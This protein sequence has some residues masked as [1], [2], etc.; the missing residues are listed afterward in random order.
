[1]KKIIAIALM[2]VLTL[3]SLTG[4]SGSKSETAATDSQATTDVAATETPE[5]KQLVI[6]VSMNSADEYAT[7]WIELF[8]KQVEEKGA[9]V[10]ST[11][12][13]SK[14]DKQLADIDT[15][16]SQ[17]PDVILV[18]PSDEMGIVSGLEAVNNANIPLIVVDGSMQ[19]N[20][21]GYNP[22][23]DQGINGRLLGEYLNKWL[24]EDPTRVANVGYIVGMYMDIVM[25]RMDEI[26]TTAP[27]AVKV[28]EAEGSWSA[29]KGMKI[30]EDWLQSHP[31]INVIAAMNDEMAIGA[32]QALE[33]AG[34]NMDDYLVF[35]VDGTSNGQFYVRSGELDATTWQDMDAAVG[36]VTEAAFAIASG[37]Q[38]DKPMDPSI[39]KLMT[40]DNIEQLVGP[41]K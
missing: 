23:V 3:V 8:T 14:I 40:K 17:Q 36:Q 2:V 22:V 31:E 4:C 9:K 25:P 1:M 35:G 41:A 39:I 16:I 19:G 24:D 38:Y 21:K 13:E 32:I 30:T 18:K 11:N 15:L 33:A 10:V 34:K 29:D 37:E 12:A 20:A 6:A 26:F 7:N 5:E 28:A 27:R